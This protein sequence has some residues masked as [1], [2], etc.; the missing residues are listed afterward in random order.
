MAKNDHSGCVQHIF[1]VFALLSEHID[2]IP[3]ASCEATSG[4]SLEY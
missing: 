3:F 4:T 1:D 2:L